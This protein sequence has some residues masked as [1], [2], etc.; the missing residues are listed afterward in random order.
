[1]TLPAARAGF[2][3]MAFGNAD[4]RLNTRRPIKF[5]QKSLERLKRYQVGACPSRRYLNESRAFGNFM[6]LWVQAVKVSERRFVSNGSPM[7]QSPS[8]LLTPR[9]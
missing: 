5:P 6:P 2:W 3:V 7:L 1:M 9:Q 8:Q 4:G